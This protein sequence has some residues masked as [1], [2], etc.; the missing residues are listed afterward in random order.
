MQVYISGKITGIEN[1]A[2]ALFQAAEDYLLS[3]GHEPVNPMK[4]DHDHDLKWESYMKLDLIALLCC[5]GIFLLSNW[6]SSRGATIEH[7]LAIDMN[8]AIIPNE[9]GL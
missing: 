4:L 2:V 6:E 8:L 1:E 5:D 3:I 7:Q 9:I